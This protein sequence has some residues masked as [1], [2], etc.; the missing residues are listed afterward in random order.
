MNFGFGAF[1]AF[2]FFLMP[3]ALWLVGF[4]LVLR[5]LR[6]FE[7]AVS[8]HERIADALSRRSTGG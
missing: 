2:L 8:A 5:F 7:R 1:P 3:V 6:A 4:Y